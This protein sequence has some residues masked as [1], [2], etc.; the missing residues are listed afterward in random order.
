MR[1]GRGVVPTIRDVARLAGVSVGTVSRVLNRK[2]TVARDIRLGVEKA[3]VALGYHP[4]PLAQGMRGRATRTVGCIIRDINIAGLARFVRAAHDTLAD[5]GYALILSNSEG[6]IAR[7]R[8]LVGVMAARRADALLIAQSTED[9]PAMEESLLRAGI[10]VV[11]FDRARPAWADAVLVDHRA[12]VRAAAARLIAL[13]HRRIALLTGSLALYPARER[14]A[15]YVAAHDAA[16]V[17]RDPGLVRTG[18]F[19]PDFGFAQSSL[20]LGQAMPPTAIIAGGIDMLPGVIRAVRAHGMR[21]PDDLSLI[22]AGTSDLAELLE[23]PV[24]VVRWDYAEV[25]RR[26]AALALQRIRGDRD[27]EPRRVVVP[28]ELAVRGSCAPPR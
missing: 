2:A 18:S 5:A 12:G 16:G 1:A 26:A 19:H 25:G 7:E 24:S 9:D 11:V 8:E 13:G 14:V 27:D 28:T 17:A 23:P 3:I 20:L 4:S 21:L 22:A 6:R 15:G 10:P